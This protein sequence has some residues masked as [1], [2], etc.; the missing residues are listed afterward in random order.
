MMPSV[1]VKIIKMYWRQEKRG[2]GPTGRKWADKF[3]ELVGGRR[4]IELDSKI[5]EGFTRI[6]LRARANWMSGD[7][8]IDVPTEKTTNMIVMGW[9]P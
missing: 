3:L 7:P 9:E 6:Q 8:A 2:G 5:P 4:V 1:R